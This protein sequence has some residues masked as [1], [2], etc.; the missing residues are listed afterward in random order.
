MPNTYLT[1]TTSTAGNGQQFT[2]SGWFKKSSTTGEI[3]NCYGG[4]TNDTNVFHWKF[5][6]KLKIE[7]ISF[8]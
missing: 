8:S 2:I 7:S 3:L 1:R 6:S 4:N 5:E